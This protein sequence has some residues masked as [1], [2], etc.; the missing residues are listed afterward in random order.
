GEA[1]RA[2]DRLVAARLERDAGLV[3]AARAGGRE[4]LALA[5]A[6]AAATAGGIATAGVTVR[7][8]VGLAVSSAGLATR[9]L[10][11]EAA[12]GKELL[13][14]DGEGKRLPA[15]AAGKGLVGVTHADSQIWAWRFGQRV[16]WGTEWSSRG[17][18]TRPAQTSG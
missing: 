13:L 12:G 4:H 11:G 9:R 16:R 17:L 2:V 10:V 18:S 8:T 3:A 5:A 15:I 1:V 6:I 14:P 7:A